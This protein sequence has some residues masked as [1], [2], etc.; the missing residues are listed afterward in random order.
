MIQNYYHWLHRQWS[1]RSVEKQ[2]MINADDTTNVEGIYVV[3]D[4]TDVPLL[5]FSADTGAKAI[6]ACANGREIAWRH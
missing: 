2:P 5:K 1:D 3:G 6:Q 4:L